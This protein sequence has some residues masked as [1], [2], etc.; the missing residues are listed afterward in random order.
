[1]QLLFRLSPQSGDLLRYLPGIGDWF[2]F[3]LDSRDLPVDKLA[4]DLIEGD[5]QGWGPPSLLGVFD[6]GTGMPTT[7]TLGVADRYRLSRRLLEL[8]EEVLK[9][10]RKDPRMLHQWMYRGVALKRATIPNGP[11]PLYQAQ[12]DGAYYLSF[13]EAVLK[14]RIDAH[15]A[16]RQAKGGQEVAVNAAFYLAPPGGKAGEVLGALLDWQAHCQAQSAAAVWEVLYQ[17]GAV[18]ARQ[19]PAERA[20][21]ARR[22]LGYAPS[23]P[24]GTGFAW[25]A[26]SRQVVNAWH[27]TLSAPTFQARLPPGS[28]LVGLLSQLKSVRADLRFREDGIHTTLT[29]DWAAAR[30]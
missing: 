11:E 4:G 28:A 1:M 25:D 26:K 3:H 15:L 17:A 22:L 13:S 21:A 2:S 30:K 20:D 9:G 16:D 19:T 14:R 8:W 7:L 12:L 18:S 29:L 10:D 24:D 23:S 6:A 5:L 27:G